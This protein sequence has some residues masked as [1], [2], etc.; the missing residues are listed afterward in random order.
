[1]INKIIVILNNGTE[2][3]LPKYRE[4]EMNMMEVFL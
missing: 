2:I 3:H 4:E 1:M